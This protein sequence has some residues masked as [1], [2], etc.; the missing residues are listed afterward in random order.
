[1]AVG[2]MDSAR[3]LPTCPQQAQEQKTGAQ[4]FSKKRRRNFTIGPVSEHH[5]FRQELNPS[6][7]VLR[8]RICTDPASR[9]GW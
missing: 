7:T 8:C 5:G 4:I 2:M 9:K 1:M 6:A 3:A